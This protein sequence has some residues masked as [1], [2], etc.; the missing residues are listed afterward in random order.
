MQAYNRRSRWTSHAQII[1]AAELTQQA[2]DCQQLLPMVKSLQ[3]AVQGTPTTITADAGY[4]DTRSL[5]DPSLNGIEMLVPPDSK[6]QVPGGSLSATAPRHEEAFRMRQVLATEQGKVRY[7]LRQSTV[8]PVFGQ[9]KEVRGIRRFHLRGLLKVT[10]E[11]KLICATHNLL[12]LF[13]HRRTLAY[14]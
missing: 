14:T 1:R 6:P 7:A 5:L 11:W 13:R 2:F 8:E 10:S 3:N 12:K 4:W 9:I